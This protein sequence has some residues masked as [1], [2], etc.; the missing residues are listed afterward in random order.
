MLYC[1]SSQLYDTVFCHLFPPSLCYFRFCDILVSPLSRMLLN[2]DY[3]RFNT[4]TGHAIPE[5][6]IH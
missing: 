5:L 2:L 1:V 4:E 3:L 6:R